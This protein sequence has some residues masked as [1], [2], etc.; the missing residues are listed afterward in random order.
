M[1]FRGEAN[2][3]MWC[4]KPLVNARILRIM[5]GDFN[6]VPNSYTYFH[7]RGYRQDAFLA[8][9]FGI[10]KSFNALAPTLRIDYILPDTTFNIHQFDMVD[11]DLSDHF[12]LVTDISLKKK[13]LR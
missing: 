8:K 7:I 2:S 4:M 5:C 12:M 6:D 13:T 10:G 11:E 3:L 9:G 1:H